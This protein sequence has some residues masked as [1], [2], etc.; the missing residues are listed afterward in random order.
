MGKRLSNPREPNKDNLMEYL[1]SPAV[2]GMKG[3][4]KIYSTLQRTRCYT[5]FPK[6]TILIFADEFEIFTLLC[7]QI[8]QPFNLSTWN[9]RL[10]LDH[11]NRKEMNDSR[12]NTVCC[13]QYLNLPW[14]Y[15]QGTESLVAQTSRI[16]RRKSEPVVAKIYVRWT[17]KKPKIFNFQNKWWDVPHNSE[18]IYFWFLFEKM[19]HPHFYSL[20]NRYVQI[21]SSQSHLERPELTKYSQETENW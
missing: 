21:S 7:S 16:G 15:K 3:N 14:N 8:P 13:A 10:R 17:W 6:S 4:K 5:E 12:D 9:V 1:R 19:T 20:K 11:E 18:N 2:V